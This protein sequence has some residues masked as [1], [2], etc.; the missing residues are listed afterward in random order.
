LELAKEWRTDRMLR[1]LHAFLIVLDR[2]H[3][4]LV[5]G[6][7]DVISPD[8]DGLLAVGSGGPYALAAARALV[9][10]ADLDA[11]G[12]AHEALTIAA[13]ICIYTNDKIVVESL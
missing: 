6:G 1:R 2:E 11:A 13:G 5:S 3:S 9:H 4:F 8:E 12:V 7:G 10:H